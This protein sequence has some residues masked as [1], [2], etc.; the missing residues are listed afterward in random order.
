[1]GAELGLL[2]GGAEDVGGED[3][4]SGELF[5]GAVGVQKREEGLLALLLG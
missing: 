1:M 3:G 2:H 4:A 5:G